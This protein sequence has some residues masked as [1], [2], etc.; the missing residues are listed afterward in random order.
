MDTVGAGEG[1]AQ[2]EGDVYTRPC[3]RWTASGG[4][5]CSMG[6]SAQSSVMTWGRGGGEGSRKGGMCVYK[7]G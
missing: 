1:R 4:L 5:L 7:A 3:V 6:G 2:W